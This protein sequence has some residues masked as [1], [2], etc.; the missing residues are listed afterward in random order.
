MTAFATQI[1]ALLMTDT[2]VPPALCAAIEEK[3]EADLTAWLETQ[4]NTTF[5]NEYVQTHKQ[6]A[7]LY[8]S[9]RS[10]EIAIET[11]LASKP[12]TTITPFVPIIYLPSN[13]GHEQFEINLAHTLTTICPKAL[14]RKAPAISEHERINVAALETLVAEDRQLGH[15]PLMVV[16]R[17]ATCV[18]GERDPFVEL[19]ELCD[20]EKMWL[21]VDGSTFNHLETWDSPLPVIAKAAHSYSLSLEHGAPGVSPLASVTIFATKPPPPPPSTATPTISSI[22]NSA[23]GDNAAPAPLLANR[24]EKGR[25][26]IEQYLK[27]TESMANDAHIAATTAMVAEPGK[28][29]NKMAATFPLWVATKVWDWDAVLNDARQAMGLTQTVLDTAREHGAY[30]NSYASSTCP[31]ALLRFEDQ[32][33][34]DEKN[35]V[36]TK[37]MYASIPEDLRTQLSIDLVQ[38]FGKLWIRYRPFYSQPPI[39]HQPALLNTLL[40][41]LASTARRVHA[42]QELRETF[43]QVV[44]KRKELTFVERLESEKEEE[45]GEDVWIGLGALRYTPPYIDALADHIAPEVVSDLDGLNMQLADV[46]SLHSAQTFALQQFRPATAENDTLPLALRGGDRSCVHVGVGPVE[47]KDVEDLVEEIVRE[48]GRLERN[49][50]FVARIASVIKRGIEQAERQLQEESAEEQPSI[51]RM[52]PIVGSVLSWWRPEVPRN[53][54]P[55]ARTFSIATGF[56]TIPLDPE[57]QQNELSPN[58]HH[59]Q[60]RLSISL[61]PRTNSNP[62]K[63]LAV[64]G[65]SGASGVV[66]NSPPPPA[67]DVLVGVGNKE[68][69]MGEHEKVGLDAN[70]YFNQELESAFEG[71]ED[72]SENGRA[73][74]S[75]RNKLQPVHTRPPL[76]PPS[77]QPTAP[78]EQPATPVTA[79]TAISA[80]A[81]TPTTPPITR[82]VATPRPR[83]ATPIDQQQQQQQQQQSPQQNSIVSNKPHSP[84]QQSPKQ[85]QQPVKP[86][87]SPPRLTPSATPWFLLATSTTPRPDPVPESIVVDDEQRERRSSSSSSS[88]SKSFDRARPGSGGS[89]SH[90][91]SAGAMVPGTPPTP[92]AENQ[93]GNGNGSGRAN[94]SVMETPQATTPGREKRAV[95][96]SSPPPKQPQQQQQNAGGM[97]GDA[98]THQYPTKEDIEQGVREIFAEY[99]TRMAELNNKKIRILLQ[100]RFGGIDLRNRVG[101]IR[102]VVDAC[103]NG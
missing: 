100:D 65:S 20:T 3:V 94:G 82:D 59:Q 90:R 40:D 72:E 27:Q 92:P 81:M 9:L 74:G 13:I 70:G 98:T 89:N 103:L 25:W 93:A 44:E 56:T 80:A 79:T 39:A 28:I 35:V 87:P 71:G 34:G 58:S 88:G 60:P 38:A 12:L 62:R 68:S 4:L 99:E 21:H 2:L 11:A 8:G 57:Q 75:A 37:F 86:Q 85:Q 53:R 69:G 49:S 15:C 29:D 7:A 97:R 55:V 76:P 31:L 95:T 73:S 61:P 32:A 30:L 23:S 6:E 19:R 41:T 54:I 36:A 26:I 66:V 18:T 43:R 16:A 64:G 14:L 33:S 22:P 63:E 96:L 84:P 77:L 50:E 83:P 47:K 17:V 42:A 1:A 48:A 102:D 67:N 24:T 101:L 51:L 91:R 10:V 5:K 52:L 45:V 78:K 46:L